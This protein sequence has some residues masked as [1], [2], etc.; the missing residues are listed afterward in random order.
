M[1]Q[2]KT[3]K[4][5][6]TKT[7][8]LGAKTIRFF[9]NGSEAVKRL[10]MNLESFEVVKTSKTT[11]IKTKFIN[12]LYAEK[13]YYGNI[14]ALLAELKKQ[15]DANEEIINGAKFSGAATD[16]KYFEFHKSFKTFNLDAGSYYE[17]PDVIEADI[18]SAY[19]R[20]AFNLGFI[21]EDFYK[22]CLLLEKIDRLILIGSIATIKTIETYEKGFL[23]NTSMEKNEL[24]RLAWFKICSYVD[25][26]LLTLKSRFDLISKDIFLFY[27]V[28]G[29]YFRDFEITN[30]YNWVNILNELSALFP[31]EWKVQRMKEVLLVNTGTHLKIQIEKLDG[32]KK[33][34]FPTRNEIKIYALDKNGKPLDKEIDL[35]NSIVRYK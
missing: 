20:T 26:A 14:F 17:I 33:E 34:F 25:S 32:K 11:N 22:K 9:G 12:Y 13:H 16:L 5:T 27:W 4:T 19:Y 7:K 2:M 21:N 23:V 18:T 3:A 6:K 10:R 35:F 1:Q 28:D 29:I 30:N 8:F 24:H 31:F 15:L